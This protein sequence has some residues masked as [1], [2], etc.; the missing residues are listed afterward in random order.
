MEKFGTQFSSKGR[1]LLFVWVHAMIQTLGDLAWELFGDLSQIL[2]SQYFPFS[3]KRIFELFQLS[4][5][6]ATSFH[7]KVHDLFTTNSD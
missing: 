4:I 6:T 3:H 7:R 2:G 5:E 1:C